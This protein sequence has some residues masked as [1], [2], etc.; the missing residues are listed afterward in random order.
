MAVAEKGVGVGD[1]LV[2]TSFDPQDGL[3][4]PL[5]REREEQTV[6]LEPVAGLDERL[7]VGGVAVGVRASRQP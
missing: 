3:A 2:R 6:D 7:R 4:A 1:A 5:V